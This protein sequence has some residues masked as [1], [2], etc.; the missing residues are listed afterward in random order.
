MTS[1]MVMFSMD[2]GESS[3]QGGTDS[4]HDKLGEMIAELST[5]LAGVKHEQEYMEVRERVHRMSKFVHFDYL[6]W[7]IMSSLASNGLTHF[8]LH[9][10]IIGTDWPAI[11]TPLTSL[12]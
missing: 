11:F 5:G 12:E 8:T 4:T 7:Q 6:V 1:K 10:Q 2:V 9:F 3:S